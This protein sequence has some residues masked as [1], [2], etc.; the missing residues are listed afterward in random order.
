MKTIKVLFV[1]LA[2]ALV[3]ASA[4]A[5]TVASQTAIGETPT[6]Q[7]T[8]SGATIAPRALAPDEVFVSFKTANT[9]VPVHSYFTKLL[10]GSDLARA[11]NSAMKP[12]HLSQNQATTPTATWTTTKQTNGGKISGENHSF[13]AGN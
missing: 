12:S 2:L 11:K 10:T 9:S 1:V 8:A 5:Q 7:M 13:K 3:A 6:V 4:N